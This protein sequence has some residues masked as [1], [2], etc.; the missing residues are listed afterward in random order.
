MAHIDVFKGWAETIRPDIDAFEAVMIREN[1]ERGYFVSFDFS[2]D[3]ERE[4]QAFRQ[5][6]GRIINQRAQR[7][8]SLSSLP[9][10]RKDRAGI[11]RRRS[12]RPIAEP[13]SCEAPLTDRRLVPSPRVP[14]L[15][16]H[17]LYQRLCEPRRRAQA[18]C[19]YS[20]R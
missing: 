1:R 8:P 4:C 12:D 17:H 15:P 3:A 7:A 6:S 13:R 5:R 10:P 20:H 11:E 14:G 16:Q 18:G 9:L 19:C 2:E